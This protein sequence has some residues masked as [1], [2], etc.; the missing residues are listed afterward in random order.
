MSSFVLHASDVPAGHFKEHKRPLLKLPAEVKQ[1]KA[2]SA[3]D[4]AK[5]TLALD[6]KQAWVC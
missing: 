1:Q 6:L 2:H 3:F 5:E 4:H